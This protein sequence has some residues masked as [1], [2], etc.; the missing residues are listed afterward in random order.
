MESCIAQ[1][2]SIPEDIYPTMCFDSYQQ[3]FP[4]TMKLFKFTFL[5]LL[6]TADVEQGFSTMNLLISPLCTSLGEKNLDRMIR[7][8]LDGPE[9]LSGKTVEKLINTFIATGCHIDF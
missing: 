4:E 3:Q 9:K 1:H 6:S 5:I 8:C 2:R 7:V